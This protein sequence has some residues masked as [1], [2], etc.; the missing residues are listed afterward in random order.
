MIGH[1][2]WALLG[3]AGLVLVGHSLAYNFVTD[4]AYISFVFARNFAEH[5]QLAFNLGQPVE[6]YTNFLWTFV[7]GLGMIAGIAPE[8]SSRVLGT[9]CALATLYVVFRTTERALGRKTAWAAVPP[10]LLA[11]S[12][13]FAC[14]T[15]GGLETQ[16]YT[17][18]VAAALDALVA[19]ATVPRALRRVGVYLALAAMTRPEGPMVAAVFGAAWGVVR[20]QAW[21]ADRRA[22]RRVPATTDVATSGAE[23]DPGAVAATPARPPGRRFADEALAIAWFV[24]LWAPWFAWRWWY[25]GWPFPNTYY[26]KATGPWA[27]PEMPRQMLGN[28]LYYVWV[29]LRQTHLLYA[30]PIAAIG[31]VAARP[32]TPRFVLAVA[33]ALFAA[34]YLSYAVSVGGDFMGLHRFIM[35]VFVVAA[36]AVTLGAERIAGVVAHR[37]AGPVIAVVLVGGFAVTQ[38]G[39]TR[40][41]LRWGN[42]A[43]DRGIDTPAFLMVYTEDRAAIGRAMAAC[44]RP[45]DFSIVGGAGAQPYAGRM[46][47]IDVFGLVSETIAH[48]E[49]RIRARAGHTKFG[50]DRV[51]AAYDPTF[52][53]SCYQLHRQPDAP[54]LPC[55]GSWLA[56]GFEPVT[57]HIP[58]MREQGEYYTF[59]AKKSRDFQCPGRVH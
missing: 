13:G 33:C 10:L 47:G 43:S 28:G 29:W 20:G 39:L 2:R 12:S 25:Y 58:G 17:L 45:D 21:L 27:S 26:V 32:R 50:S 38:L 4:D 9:V 22:A 30:L 48:D 19:A 53:F 46:R 31:L 8:L 49:P 18:L 1:A 15:S 36:L 51:L 11:C 52:V 35:P 7:L 14:W 5:G 6:G 41:S 56:R 54:A 34:V 40:A 37:A 23:A 44:L 57:M 59:L 24:A 42:F 3:L 55:A 16:L